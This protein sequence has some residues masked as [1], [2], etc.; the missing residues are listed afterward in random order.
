MHDTTAQPAYMIGPG[1]GTAIE[2]ADESD[3]ELFDKP[4][5]T[6]SPSRSTMREPRHPIDVGLIFPRRELSQ[7]PESPAETLGLTT[8]VPAESVG[9]GA[10]PPLSPL[11]RSRPFSVAHSAMTDAHRRASATKVFIRPDLGEG[12]LRMAVADDGIGLPP[13][14]GAPGHGLGS[15]REDAER[16]G[17]VHQVRPGLSGRATAVTSTTGYDAGSRSSG[18]VE[19]YV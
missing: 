14:F 9:V 7:S 2:P 18:E 3:G 13:D 12:R 5:A 16:M 11:T 8:P 19:Q 4:K 10:E 1:M 15:T 6:C 17:G